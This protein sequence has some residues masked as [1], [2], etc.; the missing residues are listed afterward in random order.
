MFTT[1]FTCRFA[2][3]TCYTKDQNKH[4]LLF[5]VFESRE[6]DFFEE[7]NF[8]FLLR[9]WYRTR[10]YSQNCT[11]LIK[12]AWPS[13]S[14]SDLVAALLIIFYS[15]NFFSYV[16]I[17]EI[18]IFMDFLAFIQDMEFLIKISFWQ[19]FPRIEQTLI[20]EWTSKAPFP[21]MGT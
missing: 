2:C 21:S 9:S 18:K 7:F 17:N 5:L 1:F 11:Q 8:E 14:N 13:H 12:Q 20:V 6:I 3:S 15:N 10:R 19:F 16:I 4:A